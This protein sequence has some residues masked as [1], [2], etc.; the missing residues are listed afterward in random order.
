MNA[1]DLLMQLVNIR[2]DRDESELVAFL[3]PLLESWGAR[4]TVKEVMPRRPNLIATFPGR[5][6]SRSLMLEAH[7]DTVGGDAPFT[8]SIRDGR[9]YGRGACDT[10]A[11]MAA[12]LLGIRAA[13][14]SITVHFVST[15]NEEHGASGAQALIAGGFRADMAVVGEP[16]ELKIVHAHK[17]AVRLKLRT[18]GVAAHSS[19]PSRGV[20][21]IYKMRAVLEKLEQFKPAVRHPLLGEPTLSVG[22]IRGGTEVNT[23]PAQCEIEVDRRIVPGEN[24]E[25]IVRSIL[26][27]LD[28]QSEVTEFYPPLEQDTA[29]PVAQRLAAAMPRPEFGIAP[30]ATNAGV[31]KAAG[32]P[33]VVFGPGSARQAHTRDEFVELAQV[34]QAAQVF[35]KLIT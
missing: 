14:P 16:T 22:I 26:T 9:L 4:V 34:E 2:T 23:V 17:G 28:V 33:C 15:C 31:F 18:T 21:A 6:S 12:M 8:A 27:G 35:R 20:N 32:I 29:S 3:A 5:D 13:Q 7:S 25:E 19:D 11:S 10:K 30:Y 1:A 24:I